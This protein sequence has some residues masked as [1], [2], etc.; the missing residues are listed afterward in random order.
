MAP[1]WLKMRSTGEQHQQ[2][3]SWCLVEYQVQQLQGR[4]VRP[5]QVFHDEEHRL[6]FG[7]FEEDGEDGFQGLVALTLRREV[8]WRIA[9]FREWKRKQRREQWHRVL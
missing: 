8:E 7:K 1:A 4:W 5:M 6:M 9:V 3:S 2:G